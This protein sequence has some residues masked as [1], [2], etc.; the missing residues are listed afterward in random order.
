MNPIIKKAVAALA[1]KEAIERVQEM[2][3]PKKPSL[4]ERLKPVFVLASLGGVAAYLV[5][6]GRLNDL[7][8]RADAG[9]P[10]DYLT[11]PTSPS[12]PATP[13]ETLDAEV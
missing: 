13:S 9:G 6:S 2:R 8:G 4:G 10:T 1:V 5:R 12:T 3:A 11:A 7:M